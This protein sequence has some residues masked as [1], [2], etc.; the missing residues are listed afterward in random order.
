MVILPVVVRF[1]L[2]LVQILLSNRLKIS[3][4]VEWYTFW[5]TVYNTKHFAYPDASWKFTFN[6]FVEP[7]NSAH[8]QQVHSHTL[9]TCTKSFSILSTLLK[10]HWFDLWT[11]RVWANT[12]N[13]PNTTC[14]HQLKLMKQNIHVN[15]STVLM[16]GTF[17]KRHLC[18][19]IKKNISCVLSVKFSRIAAISVWEYIFYV[20]SD[21]KKTWLFTFFW[22]DVSKSRKKSLA[23]V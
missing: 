19:K 3:L 2:F 4:V 18:E 8:K 9:S 6:F 11:D 22:N 12:F 16:H 14:G 1:Q 10:F 23:K 5:D 13:F 15:V 7:I 20:F 21:L 17:R